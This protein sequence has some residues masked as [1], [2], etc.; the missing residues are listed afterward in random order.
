MGTLCDVT[1]YDADPEAAAR[2]SAA[3]L[4]EM[5]RVDRL[6][7]N[8]DPKSELSVMNREAPRGPMRVS[9]ELFRFVE[10]SRDY[11]DETAGAFDPTVGPLVRAWGFF[12]PSPARPAAE[13]VA[14][15]KAASGFSKVVLDERARTVF[16]TVPGLE[17][18]PGGIGKGY[19]VDRAVAILKR[20]GITAALVSA[21]GSTLFAI[22]HPPDRTAWRIA[23]ADPADVERPFRYVRLRDAAVSTSGV[24]QQSVR[25]GTRRWSHIFDPRTGEPVEGMCQVTVVAADATASD[26]LTKAAFILE[27]AAV[28]RL[29]TR[30]GK[31][32]HAMRVEGLC[33]G[34]TAVWVTP[35]SGDVFTAVPAN[36]EPAGRTA[37]K[38]GSCG[39][40]DGP[41][42]RET[43]GPCPGPNRPPS[44]LPAATPARVESARRSSLQT[45]SW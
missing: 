13:A 27:R 45:A 14:A 22:G 1:I 32:A 25:E 6:L 41:P 12:G 24:A 9:E 39:G 42:G 34:R 33:G 28:L 16:Y 4:D 5:Q 44:S 10:R 31:N 35:W 37:S 36:D 23:V 3:A 20:R 40:A 17:F 7:S 26:A 43:F 8:Y 18:D 30:L 19:A 38:A 15:A 21:G 29:F 11:F 2:A